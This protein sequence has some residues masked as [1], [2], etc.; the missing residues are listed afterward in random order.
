MV[1]GSAQQ[2]IEKW[3]KSKLK[4]RAAAQEHFIDLCHLLEHKTPAE[5]DPDGTWY[6]FEYG[7]KKTTGSKGFADVWKKGFFGWEYKGKHKDLQAAYSQLQQYAP[8]LANPPL[9]I[10]CDTDKFII[11]TNWN[12]L[13][14]EQYEIALHELVEPDKLN[15]L[16]YAFFDPD[17]LK[18]SKSRQQLT[19]EIAGK[20]AAISQQLRKRGYEP[21]KVAHFVN[22]LIFCMF[23]E[24]IE[25]LPKGMFTQLLERGVKAPKDLE[26]KLSSLFKAMQTGGAWGMEDIL[27][28]NGGLFDDDTALTMTPEEIQMVYQT[29]QKDWSDIDPSIMGTLFERGLDPEKQSQLG[30]HYTDRDMIMK[31]IDPVIT[32][33]LRHEWEETKAKIEAELEKAEIYAGKK[34]TK[35][36]AGQ[37]TKAQNRALKL[38]NQYIAKIRKFKVLDPACGSGN[39][40][41]LALKALKDMEQEVSLYGEITFNHTRSMPEVGPENIYG[42][43]ISPYASELARVSVWIGEIQWIKKHGF[44]VPAKPVLRK[45]ENIVCHDALINDDGTE[46]DWP[47]VDVVVGNP[48]FI[49][50]KKMIRELGE[51]YVT[52][53]RNAYK[54]RVAGGADFVCFWFAKSYDQMKANKLQRAGLVSTNSIRGGKN[55]LILDDIA[56]QFHI[57]NAWPDEDWVNEGAAVRVSMTACSIAEMPECKIRGQI[58][59][60]IYTDLSAKSAEIRIDASK[61]KKLKENMNISFIGTQKNGPFTLPGTD[62]RNLLL[63]P[64]N[65]NGRSNADVIRPWANGMDITRRNSDTWIIDFG[66]EMSLADASLYEA[67]FAIVERNVKPTREHVR[68][69]NHREKW[70]LY[71]ESRPGLRQAISKNNKIIVTSMVAKHR[72]FVWLPAKQIPENLCV[73]IA[74]E[75]CTTFGII[76]SKYHVLWSLKLCTWLG[77]GNDPRYTPSTTFETFPF[78]AGMTPDIPAEQLQS[79]PKAQAIA[80]AAKKLNELRE[81]W[82]NPPDLVDRVPE[83]VEGYPD[84]IIPKNDAA[85]QTL[86]KRTLTNLYNEM[87]TWL[88]FAHEELD[89]A[90]ADAYGWPHDLSDEEILEKLFALN[91]QRGK[92]EA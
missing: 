64:L 48:P 4:E 44:T 9:L 34:N 47:K 71:G 8:A 84:R 68:R 39:F 65:P 56:K 13:V 76:S 60:G 14:S 57:Y 5:E 78:P 28:F 67:P 73:V 91:Q 29:S 23:A 30:A 36:N 10:V 51:E 35:E 82:L 50:D 49:G 55:R 62:A 88:K 72:F 81:N 83:V 22:R 7:T 19:E 79:N 70:W 69:K 1:V 74:K 18:P 66:V 89:N 87:P 15:I 42:I 45:L 3:E 80:E 24:D 61:A 31:I 92:A 86:K 63:A 16:R 54:N 20:F 75:D 52:L 85:A 37:I 32:E 2:F 41:Y 90:V 26:A 6:T 77:K 40:L 27:W 12:D 53:L 59:D 21:H 58:V 33:P 25:L 17:K 38:Y 46:Y 11:H 43:E